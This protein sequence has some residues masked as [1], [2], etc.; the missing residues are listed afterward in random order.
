MIKFRRISRLTTATTRKLQSKIPTWRE[1]LWWLVAFTYIPSGADGRPDA[2]LS[3]QLF[4][5]PW[6]VCPGW[7]RHADNSFDRMLSVGDCSKS[8]RTQDLEVGQAFLLYG[9]CTSRF[10]IPA[11]VRRMSLDSVQFPLPGVVLPGHLEQSGRP[12]AS[13]SAKVILV[14]V[15]RLGPS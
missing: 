7:A 9:L 2:G 15:A 12:F 3:R 5:P 14:M 10:V 4:N 13:A 8:C 6:S 11:K 1:V